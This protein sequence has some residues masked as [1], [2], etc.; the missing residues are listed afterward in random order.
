MVPSRSQHRCAEV[1]LF[2]TG[3]ELSNEP[4]ASTIHPP[5]MEMVR[6][7]F[8]YCS[9][10]L[11]HSHICSTH[12]FEEWGIIDAVLS[13]GLKVNHLQYWDREAR[14]IVADFDYQALKDETPYPFR[15][16]CP[17]NVV[18]KIAKEKLEVSQLS[19]LLTQLF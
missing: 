18:T 19:A 10:S 3:A 6:G 15:L 13:K 12:Q 8:R 5:S 14:K 7:S 9:P 16:Q 2:E 1:L 4:R 11:L 17:Q